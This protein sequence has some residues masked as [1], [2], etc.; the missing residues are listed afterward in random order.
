MKDSREAVAA[1]FS[2]IRNCSVPL[3]ISTPGEPN[4][5]S[6]RWRTLSDQKSKIYFYESTFY[7]TI[8]WVDFKDVD[9][10]PGAPVKMLDL[11]HG[12]TYAGNT[13][14]EFVATAPFHFL[15]IE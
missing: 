5:S 15:G 4:I 6:T 10:S 12:K 2:V 8:F 11:N 9:F 14:A 1:V 13:A 7:P 3:G